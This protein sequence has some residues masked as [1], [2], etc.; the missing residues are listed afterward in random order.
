[1]I[2]G[3]LGGSS[4][5]RRICSLAR[6]WHA[7][8]FVHART[9]ADQVWGVRRPL[10]LLQGGGHRIDQPIPGDQ[11]QDGRGQL[12]PG[13]ALRAELQGRVGGKLGARQA[14]FPCGDADCI[15]RQANPSLLI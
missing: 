8:C 12:V 15:S 11:E 5:D 6:T 4:G 13:P 1:M 14:K 2:R 9:V 7:M 3:T 10:R